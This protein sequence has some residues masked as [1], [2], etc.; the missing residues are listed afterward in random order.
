MSSWISDESN[1]T[2]CCVVIRKYGKGVNQVG[3]LYLSVSQNLLNLSSFFF[4]HLAVYIVENNRHS[5]SLY[6][7]PLCIFSRIFPTSFFGIS[8]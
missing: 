8:Y 4:T 3:T 6:F 2:L 1:E 5:N 7:V